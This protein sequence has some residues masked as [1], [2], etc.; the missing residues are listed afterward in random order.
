MHLDACAV[1]GHSLDLD[2]DDL[3]VLQL[4]EYPIQHATLRPAIHAGV[5]GVPVAEPLGQTAP[6]AP[7]LGHIQN[8]VQHPQI[9]QAHIATLSRQTMLD[10]AVLRFADFHPRSIHEHDH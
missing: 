3:I 1:Q 5:D 7:L 8:R 6:F 9:R 10:Q 4:S 2:P